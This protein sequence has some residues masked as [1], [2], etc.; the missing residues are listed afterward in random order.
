MAK[1]KVD[2]TGKLSKMLNMK[3]D[4]SKIKLIRES[5]RLTQEAL[6]IQAGV[7]RQA[8]ISWEKGGVGSFRILNKIA[9]LLKVPP[10]IFIEKPINGD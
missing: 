3:V 7:S 10:E 2:K 1:K 8:V 9:E 4:G 6:A 5:R